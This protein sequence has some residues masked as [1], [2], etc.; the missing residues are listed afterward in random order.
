MHKLPF[1]QQ[2]FFILRHKMFVTAKN[3]KLL[4]KIAEF[5]IMKFM[6]MSIFK[7]KRVIL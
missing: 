6:T 7:K 4:T 3:A 5:V 1:F 2:S